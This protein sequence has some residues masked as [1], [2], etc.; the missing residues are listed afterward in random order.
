MKALASP[1]HVRLAG[2]IG[3]PGHR[4]DGLAQADEPLLRTKIREVVKLL[5]DTGRDVLVVTDSSTTVDIMIAELLDWR[6]AFRA[7]L[8]ELSSEERGHNQ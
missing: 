3:V 8:L 7:K 2:R 5:R 4:P 1:P 6:I